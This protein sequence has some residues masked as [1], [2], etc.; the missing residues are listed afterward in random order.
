MNE[1]KR[2]KKE[3]ERNRKEVEEKKRKAERRRRLTLISAFFLPLDFP[4][5]IS[6]DV[7]IY[8]HIPTYLTSK[9][10][11]ILILT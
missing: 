5:W 9:A 11:F 1:K 4:R 7:Y 3:K 6:T 10:S 8:I 2:G